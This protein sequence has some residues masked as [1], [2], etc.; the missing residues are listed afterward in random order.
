MNAHPHRA[1]PE[2]VL[3]GGGHPRSKRRGCSGA[4]FA[5]SRVGV[6]H[7][8]VHDMPVMGRVGLPVD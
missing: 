7:S 4:R 6:P 2:E 8:R 3:P 1:L 5:V